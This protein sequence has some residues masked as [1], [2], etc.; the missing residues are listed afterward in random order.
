[1]EWFG[2]GDHQNEGDQKPSEPRRHLTLPLPQ[3]RHPTSQPRS[4]G[5]GAGAAIFVALLLPFSALQLPVRL[6]LSYQALRSL[7][8]R[9]AA[10]SSQ[11]RAS[12][13]RAL[14]VF[15]GCHRKLTDGLTAPL[16]T[17]ARY[18]NR[19]P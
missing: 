6:E 8:G 18:S 15:C 10:I 5:D 7:S 14:T 12:A 17:L 4:G 16:A 2:Q 13:P 1:M 3:A 9:G 19:M 11:A